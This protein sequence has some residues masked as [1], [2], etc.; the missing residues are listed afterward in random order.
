MVVFWVTYQ[1]EIIV[2]AWS[3]VNWRNHL[4]DIS[5]ARDEWEIFIY[6][7]KKNNSFHFYTAKELVVVAIIA[8]T[9][10]VEVAVKATVCFILEWR[11]SQVQVT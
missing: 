3:S 6:Y 7:S 8:V 1:V 11:I 10:S 9:V 5:G 2:E 4:E